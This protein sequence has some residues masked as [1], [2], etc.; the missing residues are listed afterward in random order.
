MINICTNTGTIAVDKL[1]SIEFNG[2]QTNFYIYNDP[3][4]DSH[5]FIDV[6]YNRNE[7]WARHWKSRQSIHVDLEHLHGIRGVSIT[8]EMRERV[9]HRYG[10]MV[11]TI[12]IR[13][14]PNSTIGRFEFELMMS[15]HRQFSIG[16]NGERMG[17][18]SQF[19]ENAVES[20]MHQICDCIEKTVFSRSP[21]SL[22]AHLALNGIKVNISVSHNIADDLVIMSPK[23]YYKMLDCSRWRD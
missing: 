2:D 1:Y 17:G 10:D 3:A 21:D 12:G 23:T 19:H 5:A 14:I 15:A 18:I 20:S 9:K 16:A 11:D 13:P 4:K 6:G 7:L 22:L 8:P